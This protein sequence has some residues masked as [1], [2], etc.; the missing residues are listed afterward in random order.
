MPAAPARG[1]DVARDAGR[2]Q[3]LPD[4]P[5]PPAWACRLAAAAAVAIGV[6]VVWASARGIMAERAL[7]TARTRAERDIESRIREI[8]L[9]RAA[10]LDPTNPLVVSDRAR[11]IIRQQKNFFQNNQQNLMDEG[12]LEEALA[13]LDEI[14]ETYYFHPGLLRVRGEAAMML[15]DLYGRRGDQ[16]N[17]RR[18]IEKGF[19]DLHQ[20]ARE[21]PRPKG[22][23][24]EFN[25]GGVVAAQLVG[26]EDVSV[27][28]LMKMNR[29][30]ERGLLEQ[31]G[32]LRNATQAWFALGLLPHQMRELH[33]ALLRE[34]DD[35]VLMDALRYSAMQLG[36]GTAATKVLEDLERQ[37]KLTPQ[38]KALLELLRAKNP[39]PFEEGTT[40]GEEAAGTDGG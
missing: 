16:A 2:A 30:G 32:I 38:G 36:Q 22:R 20:A 6:A 40:D 3:A 23:A 26:R 17:M 25:P 28:F 19:A 27:D 37:R 10:R 39:I 12:K 4:G 24:E 13:M 29:F 7:W 15:A 18:W 31:R 9:Q 21:L 11:F 8:D 14:D 35:R 33:A 1:K 34:P 5:R